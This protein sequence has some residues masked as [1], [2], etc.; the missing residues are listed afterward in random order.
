MRTKNRY[1]KEEKIIWALAFIN[2]LI[3]PK[4][5][6]DKLHISSGT[7]KAWKNHMCEEVYLLNGLLQLITSDERE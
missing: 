6:H 1:T 7:S 2:G 5:L 3:T 4:E